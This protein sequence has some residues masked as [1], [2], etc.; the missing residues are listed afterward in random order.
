MAEQLQLGPVL[1]EPTTDDAPGPAPG[2]SPRP[3]EAL[4]ATDPGAPAP[5]DAPAPLVVRVL[6]DVPAI[7]REFDYAVPER[8]LAAGGE[9]HVGDLVRIDLHGR[10]VGGWVTAV[11]VEPPDGVAVRPLAKVSGRGP[12][13]DL[14]DLAGWAAWRWAGR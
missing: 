4:P 6:P 12:S 9:V 14:L 3:D 2:A 8:L 13:A 11:G 7:D 5:P 10:R 1:D